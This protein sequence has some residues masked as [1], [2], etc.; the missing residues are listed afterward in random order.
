ML[1]A[2]Y[3]VIKDGGDFVDAWLQAF[4]KLTE[5]KEEDEIGFKV[6]TILDLHMQKYFMKYKNVLKEWEILEV[7]KKMVVPLPDKPYDY[8]FKA[9][10]I[11]LFKAGEF[12]GKIGIVDHKFVFNYYTLADMLQHVQL[13]RYIWGAEHCGY[14]KIDFGIL[15]QIRYRPFKD[16]AG[17]DLFKHEPIRPPAKRIENAMLEFYKAA[18]GVY[19]RRQLST[20]KAFDSTTRTLSKI[21]CKF[22]DFNK[23]CS[24]SMDGLPIKNMLAAN[25]KKSD[26]GYNKEHK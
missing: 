5:I 6:S 10:L 24:D 9:D 18:D 3:T 16:Y 17:A 26:Y 7:E 22:C 8:G 25:Y 20:Q 14:E 23:P 15:A 13:P 1:E 4:D 12:K 21:I 19:E 2:F 11:A